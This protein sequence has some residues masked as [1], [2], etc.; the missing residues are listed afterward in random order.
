M[1]DE[2]QKWQ[3]VSHS[4]ISISLYENSPL[5]TFVVFDDVEVLRVNRMASVID[6]RRPRPVS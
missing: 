5:A 4:V 1:E 6:L 3:C 2:W